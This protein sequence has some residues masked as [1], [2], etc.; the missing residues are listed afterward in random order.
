MVG[1]DRVEPYKQA[2]AEWQ[3]QLEQLHDVFLEGKRID[4]IRIKGLLNR[5]ARAKRRYDR[6]R[7]HLLGI[8]EE[9]NG[10]VDEEEA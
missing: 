10:D 8:E 1:E 9:S 5:E 2:Y 4:P 6:A 3:K 7:L